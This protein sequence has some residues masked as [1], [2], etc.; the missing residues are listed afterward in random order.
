M[1]HGEDHRLQP[2][3]AGPIAVTIAEAQRLSGFSRSG[4]YRELAAG[5]LKAVKLGSRTLVLTNSIR[6]HLASLPAAT[7]RPARGVQ[8]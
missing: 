3:I 1:F 7:F 5:S 6:E 8:K 4:V 2:I